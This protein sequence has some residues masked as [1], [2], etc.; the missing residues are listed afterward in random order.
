MNLR[1]LFRYLIPY[2]AYALLNVLFNILSV[3]FSLVSFALF[4]PV[5][6]IL[7]KVQAPVMI[8]EPLNWLDINSLTEHFYYQIGI[9][10]E[11][12]GENEVLFITSIL[13]VSFYLL[14]NL[15]RYAAM[16]FLAPVR[17][18][19]VQDLRNHLFKKIL[20]L[21]LS[22]FSKR[23]KGD[24]ITRI[25]NDVQEVEW[26]IMS[27]LEM[28]FRDP[29][30]LLSYL[31]TLIIISPKLTLFV[32]IL[33]PL[34]AFII[35]R[36][37]RKLK[38][39][40]Q[41]TQSQLGGLIA[42][43]EEAISGLRIIKAFN[44]IDSSYDSFD[45]SNKKY[46][47][48]MNAMYRRR[49]LASPLSEFLSILVMVAVLLFGGQIVL[50]DSQTLD[51]AVFI[52]YL[53]I[54][55]QIIPPAKAIGKAYYNIQRGEASLERIYEVLNADEVIYEDENA[56][57]KTTFDQ[58]LSFKEVDFKYERKTILKDISCTIKKGQNLFIVGSS[59]A[60]KS[61]FTDLIPRFFD[62]I[63][64]KI[65]LD[66][67]DLKTIKIEELRALIGI[68][69]QETIL[70]NASVYEN[71]CLNTSYTKEEIEKAAKLAHAHD[72]IMEL[73]NGYETNIGDQGV[74][75]SGGQRQRLSIARAI[76]KDAPILILDEAGSDLDPESEK[77]VFDALRNLMQNRTCLIISHHMN[78]IKDADEILV[79]D[80][81]EIIEQGT[82]KDLLQKKGHYHKLYN[83]YAA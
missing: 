46:T 41:K 5:L 4:I 2:W 81:G 71:L 48:L 38:S 33:L 58:Q 47:K 22:Y 13:I 51:A 43:I 6:Q 12:K 45:Q 65:D 60:G 61:T 55:S 17:N 77:L 39:T 32:L 21:P 53:A 37:G 52:T 11:T 72:F 63:K 62:P 8:T 57:S 59:G 23:K 35:S 34:S 14:R 27:S 16:Y 78:I 36:I 75:L 10:I 67:V 80:K 24:V 66:G 50:G 64:G 42:T 76:L 29:I 82:H 73:E 9:M 40:S 19:V 70:F 49:D 56:V 44:A 31:F 15:F 26:S 3:L 1:R 28:I 54:F 79:F 30:A 7:F 18:G 69:S 68:V 83:L 74:K 20:I 25:T